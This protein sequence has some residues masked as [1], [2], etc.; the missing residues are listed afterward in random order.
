MENDGKLGFGCSDA[1]EIEGGGRGD[2]SVSDVL[3]MTM[4]DDG[5]TMQTIPARVPPT[6]ILP[7]K[8]LSSTY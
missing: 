2:L 5:T 3:S 1:I 8:Q 4:A 7:L 6:A